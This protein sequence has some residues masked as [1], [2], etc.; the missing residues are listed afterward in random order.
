[1]KY[2]QISGLLLICTLAMFT[3]PSKADSACCY[4][5]AKDKDVNQPAQKAF[6]SWDPAE[7]VESFIVQPKFEGDAKDFGMVVPTPSRPTLK[8][9]DNE[10]FKALAVFTILKPLPEKFRVPPKMYMRAVEEGATSVTVL[11]EGV[12]GSLDYKI[13]I[14][15]K[16]DDLYAWLKENK[17]HYAGDEET[18]DFYIKK[19]W[20]FTVMRIDPKQ[21]KKKP[22]GTYSG[23]ITPTRFKFVTENCIYPLRITAI[24][25]K[26]QT[27][28]LF[29]IQA[30]RKMDFKGDFSYAYSWVPM[31][32]NAKGWFKKFD[33]PL[34]LNCDALLEGLQ[35]AGIQ[36]IQIQ[37]SEVRRRFIPSTLEWAH[38]MTEE[39]M[40]VL[41]GKRKFDREAP[42]EEIEKLAILEEHLQ[43]GQFITKIRKVF[44]KEEMTDDLVLVRARI[45]GVP[46][47]SEYIQ[48][49]P[50]SPP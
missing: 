50:T 20:F 13:I 34:P 47:N 19:G 35:A 16:A 5:S 25:V 43:E 49:L 11:E 9:A 26:D 27:E 29:Y 39:D 38:K 28:A 8:A 23:E 1:M 31:L 4:F 42:K 18:L 21:M 41:K 40:E 30:P 3:F 7:Q 33:E 32:S 6:I 44:K 45:N 12:V 22:D 48:L 14:A 2:F 15:G 17:Y 36:K 24:S 46:D 37:S 10:F